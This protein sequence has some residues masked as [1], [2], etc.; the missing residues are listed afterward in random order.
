MVRQRESWFE[1]NL[2]KVYLQ[3][4]K[5]SPFTRGL[6]TADAVCCYV[7]LCVRCIETNCFPCKVYFTYLL[8]KYSSLPQKR[9]NNETF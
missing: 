5:E 2:G 9:T 8:R 7:I 3:V 4:T 1:I 6:L